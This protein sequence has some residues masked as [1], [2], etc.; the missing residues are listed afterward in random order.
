MLSFTTLSVRYHS[1][2]VCF[3]C[4]VLLQACGGGDQSPS[5]PAPAN[6]P[7]S[8]SNLR[9]SPSRAMPYPRSGVVSARVT[10]IVTYSDSDDLNDLAS[11]SISVPGSSEVVIPKASLVISGA[12]VS[13]TLDVSLAT[14]GTRT[15]SIRAID[16][17]GNV[18]NTLAGEFEVGYNVTWNTPYSQ[19]ADKSTFILSSTSS[20]LPSCATVSSGTYTITSVQYQS[21]QTCVPIGFT[22][23]SPSS[24]AT[25]WGTLR[26]RASLCG[27]GANG[28]PIQPPVDFSANSMWRVTDP[29]TASTYDFSFG[30]T[31]VAVVEVAIY[32]K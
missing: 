21:S 17:A 11:I 27:I 4:A 15:F 25:Q 24:T 8:I 14:S 22:A 30:A 28:Q 10:G 20:A 31:G 13:V 12:D 18:S 3:G 2:L 7:P 23:T 26:G 5:Q 1:S 19:S 29:A 16:S 6:A 32:C 9:Y